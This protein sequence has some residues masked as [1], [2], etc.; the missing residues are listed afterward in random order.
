MSVLYIILEGYNHQHRHRLEQGHQLL[1]KIDKVMSL[2][3]CPHSLDL[4][5]SFKGVAIEGYFTAIPLY[6]KKFK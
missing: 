5:Q 6:I 3:L 1:K 4:W 2:A